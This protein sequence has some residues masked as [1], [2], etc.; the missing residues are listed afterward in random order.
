MNP[1]DGRRG[2]ILSGLLIF[3]LILWLMGVI[4]TRSVRVHTSD[5]ANGTDVSIDTPE[6]R[7]NIRAR[8][9]MNPDIVG[10]PTY[11]GAWATD[12][13]GGAHFEWT[14][15]DGSRDKNLYAIGG[16]FRTNDSVRQ[17]VE[18]YR[19]QLPNVMI[20]SERDE[21]TRLEYREGGLKRIISISDDDGETR[22]GV[23]SIGGRASN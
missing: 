7:L 6:G 9:R 4:V 3:C 5:G 1:L 10:V 8:D 15:A 22:I 13:T 19:K 23:A 14:P 20:V 16:E 18:F 2:G 12:N 17:V 11:P 21:S